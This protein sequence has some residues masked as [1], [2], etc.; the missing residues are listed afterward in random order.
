[1][2]IS[3]IE[4]DLKQATE[5]AVD[6]FGEQ[7]M[8]QEPKEWFTVDIGPYK[9]KMIKRVVIDYNIFAP[10]EYGIEVEVGVSTGTHMRWF[11]GIFYKQVDGE[12]QSDSEAK[13]SYVL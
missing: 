11:V 8:E 9:I 3:G 7:V 6:L 5:K 2:W 4:A 12:W 10:S 1:M 13:N